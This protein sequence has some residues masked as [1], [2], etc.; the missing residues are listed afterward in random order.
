VLSLPLIAF[1]RSSADTSPAPEDFAARTKP[2]GE[3]EEV[4]EGM[5]RDAPDVEML[6]PG[7]STDG[8]A[9]DSLSVAGQTFNCEGKLWLL[10]GGSWSVPLKATFSFTKEFKTVTFYEVK[11]AARNHE[12]R[13]SDIH[14]HWLILACGRADATS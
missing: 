10:N 11:I 3:L 2:V 7:A 8:V 1:Q 14:G 13:K 9:I 4:L 6:H 5:V 12:G